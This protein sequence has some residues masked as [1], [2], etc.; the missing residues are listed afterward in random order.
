MVQGSRG[1][2]SHSWVDLAPALQIVHDTRSLIVVVEVDPDFVCVDDL[3]ARLWDMTL[4]VI[5]V[6][7]PLVVRMTRPR[8]FINSSILYRLD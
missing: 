2:E 7:C 6:A 8:N 1:V 5:H 4:I 3:K